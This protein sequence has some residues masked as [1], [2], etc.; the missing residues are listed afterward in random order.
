MTI[1]A[2]DPEAARPV[3]VVKRKWIPA[4]EGIWP[5]R[6]VDVL[7]LKD[8]VKNYAGSP[9]KTVD[10]VKLVWQISERN[11]MSGKR[12][13]TSRKF[14]LSLHKKSTLRG[15][16]TSWRGQAFTAEELAGFDIEVL[17]GVNCLLQVIH[18]PGR[19][20]GDVYATVVSATR[21]RHL[22]D[23]LEPDLTYIRIR[24]RAYSQTAVAAA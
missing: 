11:E 12:F 24:D 16:L 3:E 6:C 18:T 15:F 21:T 4:P 20:K 10:E 5:A 8:V 1:T 2:R 13:L 9:S 7:L 23:N 17:V 19:E 22:L 14:T